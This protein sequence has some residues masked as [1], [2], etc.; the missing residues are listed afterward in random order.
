MGQNII[1]VI[2]ATKG[3]LFV[4]VSGSP[5]LRKQIKSRGYSL[6]GLWRRL[7]LAILILT[8]IF[9]LIESLFTLY[10]IGAGVAFALIVYEIYR[11]KIPIQSLYHTLYS[12]VYVLMYIMSVYRAR[13]ADKNPYQSA[14]GV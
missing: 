10:V 7:A 8:I 3:F 4:D 11:N 13:K 14:S 9:A 12:W 1:N 6:E 5:E 2:K